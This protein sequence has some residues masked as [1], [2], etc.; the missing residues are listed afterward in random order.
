MYYKIT[1]DWEG[2]KYVGIDLK[3]DYQIMTLDTSVQG[4]VE[5]ALHTQSTT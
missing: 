3:W 2:K 5:Q 1:V 4:Y